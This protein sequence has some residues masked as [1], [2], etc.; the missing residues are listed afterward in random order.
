M[1][2]NPL[3]RLKAMI[4]YIS[5]A[6]PR[7]ALG[8]TKLHKILWFSDREMYLRNGTTIS[9]DTYI[10]FPQGPMS[11]NFLTA[12]RELQEEGKILCRTIREPFEPFEFISLVPPDIS[13]FTPEEI[14]IIG[15][16]I[17][18]ISPLSARRVSEISHDRTWETYKDG[19]EISMFSVLAAK[20]RE[21]TPDDFEWALPEE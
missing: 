8:K 20:T 1:H 15:R 18:W 16:Q 6:V 11:K 9:G 21:F 19:E 7:Q 5:D 2:Q 13:S 4:H 17:A 14:D 12:Q 10:R 3:T